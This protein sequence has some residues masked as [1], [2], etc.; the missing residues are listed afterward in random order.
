MR[1]TLSQFVVAL[2]I[3]V[4]TAL[5]AS[6]MWAQDAP[7]QS[8]PQ[9]GDQAQDEQA[10][11]KTFVGKIVKQGDQYVLKDM[12]NKVTYV[13]DGQD[14]AQQFEGRIVTV[15]GSLDAATNTIHVQKIKTPS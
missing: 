10:A 1:K 12:T 5:W 6:T 7:T 14:E 2:A 4:G 3:V 8:Q 13:L 9:P 15:I 11:A